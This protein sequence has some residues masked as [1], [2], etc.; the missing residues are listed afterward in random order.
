MILGFKLVEFIKEFTDKRK[1]SLIE[2]LIRLYLENNLDEKSANG[3]AAALH[4]LTS[5][6]KEVYARASDFSKSNKKLIDKD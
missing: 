6:N 2:K 3:I 5:L 1:K 4:E